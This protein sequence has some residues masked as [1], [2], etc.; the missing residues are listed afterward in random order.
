MEEIFH[1]ASIIVMDGLNI[2]LNIVIASFIVTAILSLRILFASAIQ[3]T[4][5]LPS[6][7]NSVHLF[8]GEKMDEGYENANFG[9]LFFKNFLFCFCSVLIF[10][11]FFSIFI[12]S[13]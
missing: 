12:K 3:K 8:P 13:Y 5:R 10:L 1:S 7:W 9:F 2:L 6:R 11:L 4:G